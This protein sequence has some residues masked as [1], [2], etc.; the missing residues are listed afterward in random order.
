MRVQ[1]LSI[2]FHNST[3]YTLFQTTPQPKARLVATG[4]PRRGGPHSLGDTVI[5]ATRQFYVILHRG[6]KFQ[7]TACT[8]NETVDHFFPKSKSAAAAILFFSFLQN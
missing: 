8:Y 3:H 4:W 2:T 1:S 5:L 6:S 7:Q